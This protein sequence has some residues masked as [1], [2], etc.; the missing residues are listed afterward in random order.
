MRVYSHTKNNTNSDIFSAKYHDN[1]DTYKLCPDNKVIIFIYDYILRESKTIAATRYMIE[2]VSIEQAKTIIFNVLC[3]FLR[4][5][6]K[7]YTSTQ[8][9]DLI[10]EHDVE[11][12]SSTEYKLDN[13]NLAFCL[14]LSKDG[15]LIN[16]Q[17]HKN[18]L[19]DIS[20]FTI[21]KDGVH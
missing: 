14:F 3:E 7:P 1:L 20:C 21:N 15:I 8:I 9:S 10:N 17:V 12:K 5:N 13:E 11:F 4:T 6:D 19:F 2:F 16:E 18:K